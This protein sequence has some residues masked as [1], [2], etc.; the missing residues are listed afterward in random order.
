MQLLEMSIL[1]FQIKRPPERSTLNRRPAVSQ[2]LS[3]QNGHE[4]G[5][6]TK[7][8][9]YTCTFKPSKRHWVGDTPV[10]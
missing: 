7:I 9:T 4:F 6:S 1:A 10:T 8:K 3:S 2:S 5:V